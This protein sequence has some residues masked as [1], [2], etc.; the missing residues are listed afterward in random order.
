MEVFAFDD[1]VSRQLVEVSATTVAPDADSF[2]RDEL[3]A[4][5]SGIFLVQ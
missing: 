5:P 3:A 1:A 2:S 4:N